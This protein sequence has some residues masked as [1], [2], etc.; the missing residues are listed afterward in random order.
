KEIKM[1][2]EPQ[3]IEMYARYYKNEITNALYQ[4][5]NKVK[6]ILSFGRPFL[7]YILVLVNLFM[8]LYV[9]INGGSTL[10]NLVKFGAKYNPAIID[11][12]WWRIISS[13]FLHVGF[14]HFLMNMIALYYLGIAVERIYGSWRFFIIYLSAGIGG[15]LAS[16]AFTINVAAGASGAIF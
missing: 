10:E 5:R 6:N 16:F 3:A 8:F 4:Q 14:I 1:L 13:M 2:I 7:T 9:E 15:G 11:G 12:Q